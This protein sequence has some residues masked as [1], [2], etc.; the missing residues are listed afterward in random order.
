MLRIRSGLSSVSKSAAFGLYTTRAGLVFSKSGFLFV[1]RKSGLPEV[2]SKN[3]L[4]TNIHILCTMFE[5][6]VCPCVSCLWLG[7]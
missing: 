4:S 6:F 2:F 1:G 5:H 7:Y 3:G